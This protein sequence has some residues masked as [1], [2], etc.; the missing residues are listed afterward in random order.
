M[1]VSDGEWSCPYAGADPKHRTRSKR[2]QNKVEQA[3]HIAAERRNLRKLKYGLPMLVDFSSG[4]LTKEAF[5]NPPAPPA[6]LESARSKKTSS[7]STST[8]GSTPATGRRGKRSAAIAKATGAG[9]TVSAHP[10]AAHSSVLLT[11]GANTPVTSDASIGRSAAAPI[12]ILHQELVPSS[13]AP[14]AQPNTIDLTAPNA[15][16]SLDAKVGKRQARQQQQQ[17]P[18]QRQFAT[19]PN[20]RPSFPQ[21]PQHLAHSH[22]D[23]TTEVMLDSEI[24]NF[25]VPTRDLIAIGHDCITESVALE[26]D[27]LVLLE[28]FCLPPT[29]DTAWADTRA[30]VTEAAVDLMSGVIQPSSIPPVT[31]SEEE[32]YTRSTTLSAAG[33]IQSTP[34]SRF[35]GRIIEGLRSMLSDPETQPDLMR[36]LAHQRIEQIYRLGS[37]VNTYE[38]MKRQVGVPGVSSDEMP[39]TNGMRPAR[40]HAPPVVPYATPMTFPS[41]DG[42]TPVTNFG[43][44]TLEQRLSGAISARPSPRAH[45]S[46]PSPHSQVQHH[47]SSAFPQ[48][49]SGIRVGNSAPSTPL[50]FSST[51]A[52]HPSTPHTPSHPSNARHATPS[53]HNNGTRMRMTPISGSLADFI[54]SS[55]LSQTSGLRVHFPS[56]AGSTNANSRK[57]PNENP[58]EHAPNAKSAKVSGQVVPH[59]SPR[60]PSASAQ[61]APNSDSVAIAVSDA[62]WEALV[63]QGISSANM[64]RAVASAIAPTTTTPAASHQAALASK[65]QDMAPMSMQ[66]PRVSAAARQISNM[67][68]PMP[69]PSMLAL[70]APPAPIVI[71]LEEQDDRSATTQ[72]DVA[73]ASSTMEIDRNNASSISGPIDVP[74]APS[75][76]TS[77]GSVLTT[78]MSEVGSIAK[79]STAPVIEKISSSSMDVDAAPAPSSAST[80]T[81]LNSSGKLKIILGRSREIE[82]PDAPT[83]SNI[84]PPKESTSTPVISRKSSSSKSSKAL[85]REQDAKDAKEAKEAKESKHSQEAKDSQSKPITDSDKASSDQESE[86]KYDPPQTVPTETPK[87]MSSK[88]TIPT[89]PAGASTS[90]SSAVTPGSPLVAENSSDDGQSTAQSDSNTLMVT[91]KPAVAW[92]A[93]RR[94]DAK[95]ITTVYWTPERL[96]LAKAL[97][98]ASPDLFSDIRHLPMEEDAPQSHSTIYGM[99]LGVINEDNT[100]IGIPLVEHNTIGREAKSVSLGELG[101]TKISRQ[102]ATL[103]WKPETKTWDLAIQG[104]H[105]VRVN[106]T[107]NAANSV[108]EVKDGDVLMFSST[109]LA[110]RTLPEPI[111]T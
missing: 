8:T 92:T 106:D 17:Q 18:Q 53:S 94:A 16:S 102:H 4:W 32:L 2:T 5:L 15:A 62:D 12:T 87:K 25:F 96:A 82:N 3:E 101:G 79:T 55:A 100:V 99:L 47:T 45:S 19:Q 56:P 73:G 105:G 75:S 23:F 29:R 52:Q 72:P 77:L 43:G 70:P 95:Q 66:A 48:Q 109:R 30:R 68:A 54:P 49:H 91:M 64:N 26:M 37:H 103:T 20:A 50:L 38:A 42:V 7:T 6:P 46:H 107:P 110:L 98:Y 80:P 104:K 59:A 69:S 111:Q 83:A 78:S 51:N 34:H 57:R 35:D 41:Y 33:L 24:P 27:H 88:S 44:I 81:K 10:R 65:L 67:S 11:S 14:L 93:Q 84:V 13:Q 22:S 97:R 58:E 40:P 61:N 63:D 28:R 9:P 21:H 85:E 1:P 76:P 36:F 39:G 86:K 71:D 60:T 74:A 90:A 108:V 31:P 89:T